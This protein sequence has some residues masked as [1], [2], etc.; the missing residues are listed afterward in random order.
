[1]EFKSS[2]VVLWEGLCNKNVNGTY[3]VLP[4]STISIGQNI[5]EII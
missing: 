1:M 5:E 2:V 4:E 3:G